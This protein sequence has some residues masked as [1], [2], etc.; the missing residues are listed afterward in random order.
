[1]P[2]ESKS[3]CNIQNDISMPLTQA[4]CGTAEERRCVP[5]DP[6]FA[7][8]CERPRW[9]HVSAPARFNAM[10]EFAWVQVR[11][12]NAS[13]IYWITPKSAHTT[14][15]NRLLRTPAFHIR[16]VVTSEVPE[17]EKRR[18]LH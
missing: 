9:T 17:H 14:I 11:R 15:M 16:E 6:S 5:W 2:I 13:A 4:R 18:R 8:W 10:R 7:T 3:E 1:M 12:T